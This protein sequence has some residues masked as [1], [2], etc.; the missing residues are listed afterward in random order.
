MAT[1]KILF[2]NGNNEQWTEYVFQ[3]EP[4]GMAVAVDFPTNQIGYC[5]ISGSVDKIYKSTDGGYSWQKL[6]FEFPIDI[7]SLAFQDE[8]I[9]WVSLDKVIY[10]TT[11]GGNTWQ[12]EFEVRKQY[13]KTLLYSKCV[14]RF[15]R[16]WFAIPLLF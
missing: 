6:P 11:D 7:R 12:N 5:L 15:C 8:N 4:D 2:C 10:K 1:P 3:N 9:G 14:I 13:Q 16:K